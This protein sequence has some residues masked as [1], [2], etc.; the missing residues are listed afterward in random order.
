[1]VNN[2]LKPIRDAIVG[3][4]FPQMC[5]LCAGAI[6]SLDDGVTCEQ[7]WQQMPTLTF[8]P[9]CTRCGLPWRAGTVSL[10]PSPLCTQC[11]DAGFSLLRFVGPYD[12]ALRENVLFLKNHPYLCRRLKAMIIETFQ[13]EAVLHSAT[14]VVPVPLHPLRQKERG[15]NQA[16]LIAQI[17]AREAKIPPDRRTV[18]RIKHTGPHRAGMDTQARAKSVAAAFAVKRPERVRDQTILLIDDVFTTGATLNACSQA[19]LQAGARA[20]YGFTVAR[21]LGE[22]LAQSR[23]RVPGDSA[24]FDLEVRTERP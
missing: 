22:F 12:G 13:R 6:E 20:V 2:W 19:L 3:L 11:R 23:T 1:M 7:C 21:V 17:I 9:R 5:T 15:F 10:H 4:V 16:E 8:L 24:R 18:V 14:Q